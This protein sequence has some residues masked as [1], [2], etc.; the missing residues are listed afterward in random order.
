VSQVK[1]TIVFVLAAV[2]VQAADSSTTVSDSVEEWPV[3]DS[4]GHYISLPASRLALDRQMWRPPVYNPLVA[5]L[6][7]AVVPGAGQVY[8][9]TR[10]DAGK[11]RGRWIKGGLFLAAN[12]VTAG[13]TANRVLEYR[14]RDQVVAD[15]SLA[16][17]QYRS[18]LDTARDSTQRAMV[19][20]QYEK[21]SMN[22]ELVRFER[23]S[24]RYVMYQ[25]IGWNT[26]L[27]LFNILD[28]VGCSGYFYSSSKKK[29][30]LAAWLSAIPALG[31]GQFYNG[32]ISKAGMIWM[33]QTM[34]LNMAY[35]YHRLMNDCIEQQN[36][37]ADTTNWRSA[38]RDYPTEQTGYGNN[39]EGKYNEAFRR[40]NLYLWYAIFF[41]FY[42]VFDAVVDAHLHDYQMKIRMEPAFDIEQEKV[43][44]RFA[45]D[46]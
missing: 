6:L 17:H 39:W 31:L 36:M 4:A 35:N 42:G 12:G 23:R 19:Q 32:S 44:V 16:V 45:W 29:P 25:S 1:R 13:V 3:A 20:A 9:S 46:F 34:L 10:E 43:G 2:T 15:T 5:G 27:Y 11:R 7:S 41:Y 28:A 33:V 14:W 21:T 38:Y 30:V 37:L 22:Y 26:G 18:M 8:C 24:S 40:R